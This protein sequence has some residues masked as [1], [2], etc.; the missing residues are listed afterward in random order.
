MRLGRAILV[1]LLALSLSSSAQDNTPPEN[2][3]HFVPIKDI[4]GIVEVALDTVKTQMLP[5][6]P[7]LKSAEFDFQ[8]VGTKDTA[9]G[10][11]A[12][13]VTIGV[14]HKKVT[15]Q[16][17][18]FTYSVPDKQTALLKLKTLKTRLPKLK[19]HNYA[20]PLQSDCTQDL[21][22]L[23]TC[24]WHRITT[25]ANPEDIVETLPQAIVAAAQEARDVTKV[26]NA[27]GHDASHRTFTIIL[28][29]QVAN[30]F[31]GGADPSSLIPVGPQ[32][33][34]TGETDRTQTLKLTFEDP[35]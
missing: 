29:Y 8:T 12:S 5:S 30:S 7:Q 35:S 14:E 16:E 28:N 27:L 21:V 15:T 3:S 22:S 13:V 17:A 34:Y 19:S 4:V 26:K 10:I 11:F 6:D 32:L 23:V 25:A 33:K 1:L 2:D 31:S 9:G 18:D 24:F 20:M